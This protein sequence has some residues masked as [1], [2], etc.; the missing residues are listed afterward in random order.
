[1]F[2]E[3]LSNFWI[4][5]ENFYHLKLCVTYNKGINKTLYPSILTAAPALFFTWKMNN[6][7]TNFD[8]YALLN[9]FLTLWNRRIF[10]SSAV[11]QVWKHCDSDATLIVSIV[12]MWC[13]K[14]VVFTY[15][16]EVN[17]FHFVTS[18]KWLKK[19]FM[20]PLQWSNVHQRVEL[21][22]NKSHLLVIDVTVTICDKNVK[23]Q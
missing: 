8:N 7:S 17:I 12:D 6:L 22:R 21:W 2:D 18:Y 15:Y 16:C 5:L 23:K 14:W 4:L 19:P 3:I 1:M 10:P 11:T 9:A 13:K 20:M